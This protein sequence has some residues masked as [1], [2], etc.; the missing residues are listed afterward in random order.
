MRQITV[1]VPRG[2]GK[3][4]LE[5]MDTENGINVVQYEGFDEDQ[6]PVD[7]ITAA[8]PNRDLQDL[9]HELEPLSHVHVNFY[10]QEVIALKPPPQKA[11]TALTNVEPRSPIEI[12]LQGRQSI[13]SWKGFLGYAVAAGVV[14]WIGLFTNTL[15]L[16]I[17]AMLIAPFAGPAMNVAIASATGDLDLFKPSIL[18]YVVALLT[19]ITTT[20]GLTWLLGQT[21]PTTS[22]IT[23]SFLNEVSVLL[24]LAAGAA[25]ALNLVQSE[26]SS[27]VPGAAV[28]ILIAASLA[29]PAGMVG[30]SVAVQAWD[31][32]LRGLFTLVI[33][34]V[35]I[36]LAGSI[37]FRLYGLSAKGGRYERGKS[38]IFYVSLVTT[39]LVL[40]GLLSLQFSNPPRLQR[41]SESQHAADDIAELVAES[42]M[43]HLI[44]VHARF[45]Q[46]EID[47]KPVLFVQVY[48][49]PNSETV[50]PV[51]EIDERLQRDIEARLLQ[52]GYNV[53]P[54]VQVGV[55]ESSYT[56]GP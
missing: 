6:N 14:V 28:G 30:M 46:E 50:V 3:R 53:V 51:E 39:L 4:V 43:A 55:V 38:K 18:R 42:G 21:T 2:K 26:G 24:P 19:T 37:I 52:K 31:M 22:M 9:L 16:L 35:G 34:L 49:Y 17:A 54:L 56:M 15:F 8:L 12:F 7:I 25:G 23:V 27:L 5:I 47:G 40:G 11:Y 41:A 36:N 10:P 48:V 20:M 45:V 44:D 13:G 29:P 32:A 1:H 33:Q